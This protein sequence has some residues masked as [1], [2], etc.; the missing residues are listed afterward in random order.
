LAFLRHNLPQ[1]T[2]FSHNDLL[3]NNI[4]VQENRV[5]FIDYEYSSYNYQAFDIANFFNESY[6]DYNVDVDPYF[7]KDA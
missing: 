6:Y 2:C 1:H 7:T 5:V 4:L 3:A